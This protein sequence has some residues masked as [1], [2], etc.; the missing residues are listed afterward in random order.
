MPITS[1]L[2]NTIQYDATTYNTLAIHL[3]IVFGLTSDRYPNRTAPIYAGDVALVSSPISNFKNKMVFETVGTQRFFLGDRVKL[4]S[5]ATYIEYYTQVI[6]IDFDTFTNK[7]YYY[8]TVDFDGSSNADV[9]WLPLAYRA[10]CALQYLD[11]SLWKTLTTVNAFFEENNTSKLI[12]N[13]FYKALFDYEY[14]TTTGVHVGQWH[15]CRVVVKEVYNDSS[16]NKE[17]SSYLSSPNTVVS[18]EFKVVNSVLQPQ[19]S[20]GGNMIDY[21][22]NA[23][24]LGILPPKKAM[25][26]TMFTN[27]IYFVGYPFSLSIISD[28]IT[29]DIEGVEVPCEPDFRI[30]DTGEFRNVD[31]NE[32][33]IV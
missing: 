33:R 22:L 8:T 1:T 29:A 9:V 30:V 6:A 13:D 18:A 2:L 7:Y 27:P 31:T 12:V 32:L 15:I 5:L 16:F 19:N 24:P 28:G 23:N 11:G 3:P 14:K 25:F 20:R 17:R 4:T 21:V 26:Q 10:E